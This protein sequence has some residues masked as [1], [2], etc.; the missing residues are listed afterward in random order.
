MRPPRA[1]PAPHFE[2][3][4]N[5]RD[6]GDGTLGTKELSP[7]QART[8]SPISTMSYFLTLT[9]N[10]VKFSKS[11]FLLRGIGSILEHRG[12]EFQAIHAVDLPPDEP[13]TRRIASQFV[14]DAINQ[15][16]HSS[17]I[18]MVTPATKE[19]SPTLLTTLLNLLPDNAFS[20]KPVLLFATG[21]LP[22]HVAVLERALRQ[23]L[24]RLGTNKIAARIH[25]GTGSWLMVG[26]ERPRLSR[27]AE[28][29]IANA[30]D[31]VLR[32]VKP[33]S[34]GSAVSAGSASSVEAKGIEAVLTR[35][36]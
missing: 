21:G 22:G 34:A 7:N 33:G 12:I 17:A 19:S 36:H 3:N 23:T 15:I 29:E 16:K 32:T 4:E 2:R 14:S 18:V 35:P 5:P 26:D 20:G 13:A 1:L 25:I 10:P 31:L 30:I 24:L 28:R 11:G 6:L 27:G 8:N 9:G